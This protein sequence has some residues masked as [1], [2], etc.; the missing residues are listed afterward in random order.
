MCARSVLDRLDG[1]VLVWRAPVAVAPAVDF[2]S[3]EAEIAQIG[4]ETAELERQCAA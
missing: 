4:A 3:M 1:H 2:S